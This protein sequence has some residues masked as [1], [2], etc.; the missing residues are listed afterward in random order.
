MPRQRTQE[1]VEKVACEMTATLDGKKCDTLHQV[2][3][4]NGVLGLCAFTKC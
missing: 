2:T 3:V 1:K 4:S